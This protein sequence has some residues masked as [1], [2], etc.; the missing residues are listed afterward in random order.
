MS[1]AMHMVRLMTEANTN[2]KQTSHASGP[3]RL[4]NRHVIALALTALIAAVILYTTLMPMPRLPGPRGT[5]KTMHLLAFTALTFPTALMARRH[6]LWVL[7]AAILLGAGI[8]ILQPS[9]GRHREFADLLA[10]S[11][12]AILGITIGSL[13]RALAMRSKKRS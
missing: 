11:A 9:F 10:D 8:E 5:D 12:G 6:L 4:L 3:G 2:L 13:L 1:Q 7:P